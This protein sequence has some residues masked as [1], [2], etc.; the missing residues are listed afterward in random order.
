MIKKKNIPKW[1]QLFISRKI[2]KL[3]LALAY[4]DK[5]KSSINKNRPHFAE[6]YLNRAKQTIS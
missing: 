6:L 4:L 2:A 5:A 1:Y 3:E